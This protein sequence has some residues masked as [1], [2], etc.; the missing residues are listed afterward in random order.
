MWT[1][2]HAARSVEQL[3]ND[4]ISYT[5][6]DGQLDFA[7]NIITVAPLRATSIST[8]ALTA[9][10]ANSLLF[11][12][13]GF[14]VQ[15]TVAAIE[16]RLTSPRMARIQDRVIQ[17]HYQQLIGKNLAQDLSEDDQIYGGT[18]A[19][20]GIEDLPDWNSSDFGCVIDLQPHQS[21]P[22]SNPAIIRRVEIRLDIRS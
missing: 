2:W 22:S 21:Y 6:Y 18:L 16:L 19:Q 8:G 9:V 15:G 20:W 17:L 7:Q 5:D 4:Q 14:A 12:N 3:E 1:N 10:E 13:F 11:K